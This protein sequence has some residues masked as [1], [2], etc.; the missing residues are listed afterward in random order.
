MTSAVQP[1]RRS[2]LSNSR[3]RDRFVVVVGGTTLVDWIL[4][5]EL[6]VTAWARR[7]GSD[8]RVTRL[9][10]ALRFTLAGRIFALLRVDDDGLFFRRWEVDAERARALTKQSAI[11]AEVTG[12]N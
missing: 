4:Q 5:I 6:E 10:H 9:H 2:F 7:T 1:D 3:L 11:M 8:V 12:H